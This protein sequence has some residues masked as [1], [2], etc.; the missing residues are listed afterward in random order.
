MQI[1]RDRRSVNNRMERSSD[2]RRKMRRKTQDPLFG[3]PEQND[4]DS[5]SLSVCC[6]IWYIVE[7]KTKIVTFLFFR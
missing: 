6:Y 4:T 2:Q 7:P 3:C 5:P 1:D